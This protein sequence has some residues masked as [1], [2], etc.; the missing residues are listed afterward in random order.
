LKAY[1]DDVTKLER[2]WTTD[3]YNVELKTAKDLK[4]NVCN[5]WRSYKV[6]VDKRDRA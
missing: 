1:N 6:L 3:T 4:T 2:T 5:E